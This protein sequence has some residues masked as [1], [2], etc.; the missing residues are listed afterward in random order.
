MW[1]F[2]DQDLEITRIVN[3][4]D[5]EFASENREKQSLK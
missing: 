5:G 1:I 3:I 4:F 2:I